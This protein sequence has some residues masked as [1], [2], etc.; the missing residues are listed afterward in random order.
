MFMGAHG[1][2][3]LGSAIAIA[4]APGPA[5]HLRI[6]AVE[7]LAGFHQSGL[8]DYV[9]NGRQRRRNGRRWA[10]AHPIGCPTACLDGH[11]AVCPTTPDQFLRFCVML[12][13]PEFVDDPRFFTGDSRLEHADVF[14]EAME[15]FFA[16]RTRDELFASA[17]ELGVPL[18]PLTDPDE[19]L[20]DPNLEGRSFWRDSGGVKV[21]DL[22]LVKLPPGSER[23]AA[24][25][26]K[27]RPL[28][29]IRVV[30]FSKV[31]AGPLAGRALADLGAEVVRIESPWLRGPAVVPPGAVTTGVIYPADEPGERPWNRMGIQNILNRSK[32]SVC[33]D[34]KDPRGRAIAQQLCEQADVIVDNNRPGALDRSGLGYEAVS[35]GNP[36][37][38]FV[39]ISGYGAQSE[40]RD[41][42][43]Y[44]PVT[45]AMAGIDWLIRDPRHPDVPLQ[46]GIGL[47]DPIIAAI[48][49]ARVAAGL[50]RRRATGRGEFIDLSQVEC[51]VTFL[52]DVFAA[53]QQAGSDDR[54]WRLSSHPANDAIE[55]GE[56]RYMVVTAQNRSAG[57]DL[58]LDPQM[59]RSDSIAAAW[60]NS[61]AEVLQSEQLRDFWIDLDHP[62]VGKLP[63]DGN[64]ILTAAGRSTAT[65]FPSLGENNRD[66]MISWLGYSAEEAATAEADG[67]L[68][69]VP[70]PPS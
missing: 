41:Y 15:R 31:W 3:A 62:D 29:G 20:A 67:V 6:A 2:A 69:T 64:P 68:M 42:P 22:G 59:L 11:V 28:E 12:E 70:R 9:C 36:G 47:P 24:P 17:N 46:T 10:N 19:V 8:I 18:A 21:P 13:R 23:A 56:G 33:L 38:I 52:G 34:I 32:Q 35:A 65:R 1:F 63:Y 30:E 27:R 49:T 54:D 48:A 55:A 37:V 26:P 66:V 60:D 57:A 51:A 39:G 53:W 43:A 45:E 61:P 4:A 25:G 7:V 14:D 58:P 44:G 40:Y 16:T 5:A 50:N